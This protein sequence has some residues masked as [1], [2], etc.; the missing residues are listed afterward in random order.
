MPV[1]TPFRRPRSVV[2]L[3]V[4]LVL[5]AG[6]AASAA[7]PGGTRAVPGPTGSSGGPAASASPPTSIASI[8]T[9]EAALARVF[10]LEPRLTGIPAF[11]P[12]LIGQSAWHKVTAGDGGFQV[13]AFL[14]WGDC[15]AGCIERHEWTYLVAENGTVNLIKDQGVPVPPDGWP[16]PSGSGATGIFGTAAAGPVCPVEQVGDPACAARPVPGAVVVIRDATGQEVARATTDA[17]GVFFV[18]LAPGS[19]VVEGQP[20]EGLLGTPQAFEATVNEAGE[21]VIS[22]AY[23]TGIR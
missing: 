19:Y 15:M 21:T 7:S 22:I 6:C 9:P 3:F 14:G 10:E 18:Q 16:S 20:V 8:T 4:V 11:D 13:D 2:F 5:T 1:I 12:D 23:D 17:R